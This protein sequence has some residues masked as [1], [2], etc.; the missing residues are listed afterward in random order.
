MKN[1]TIPNKLRCIQPQA[2]FLAI[3]LCFF[4]FQTFAQIKDNEDLQKMADDDQS[5]RMVAKIDWAVLNKKDSLRRSRVTR[6]YAEDK[7][8]TAKDYLNAG[9]VFQ[10]G[11]DTVASA[12]A[13][14]SFEKA[15]K[16]DSTLNRWWY[17]AAVDRDLMRRGKPQLYG[18]Q[19]IK[20]KAADG[21]WVRYKIDTTKVTDEERKYYR[22]ETLKEQEEKERTMN[23]KT[24]SSYYANHNSAG[25]TVDHI[26]QEFK[27]GKSSDYNINEEAVN[28][29]AYELLNRNKDEEALQVF[30][31]NTELYPK[32]FNTFDSYGEA[33]MKTGQKKKGL[34]AYKKSLELNPANDN[35]RE[36]LKNNG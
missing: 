35:A 10:H 33:L 3:L 31:L 15:I 20:N 34:K 29:F 32:A 14:K 1:P 28:N 25:K 22:V 6:L 17:A 30:K 16:L 7:V 5:E 36:I 11:N 4:S 9:I 23:L 27:K 18:T 13:V 21:K 19:F 8:K 24:I 26:R 12:M 2:G